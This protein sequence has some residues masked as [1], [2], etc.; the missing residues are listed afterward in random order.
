MATELRKELKDGELCPVCG[1]AH[2]HINYKVVFD[3]VKFDLELI[4]KDIKNKENII[5]DINNDIIKDKTK[6]S[7][8]IKNIE[9]NT[10][11]INKLGDKFRE[12]SIEILEENFE[13]LKTEIESYNKNK[14]ELEVQINKAAVEREKQE[15][16]IKALRSA[17]RTYQNQLGTMEKELISIKN[18]KDVLDQKINTLKS[19]ICVEQFK[20]KNSEI[21]KIE[22]ERNNISNEISK[23]RKLLGNL[24][25]EKEKCNK[26]IKALSEE[27]IKKETEINSYEKKGNLKRLNP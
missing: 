12:V 21:R 3:E 9:E 27:I 15:G 18:E 10:E 2:H 4:E 8:C 24:E 13:K 19:E 20:E 7:V 17:L 6:L 23:T 14:E 25:T 5:K 26:D 1:S 22:I 11:S 16:E